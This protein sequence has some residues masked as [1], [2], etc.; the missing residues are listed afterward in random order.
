MMKKWLEANIPGS[1]E[2]KPMRDGR[3]LVLAKNQ[4]TASKAIQ[5]EITFTTHV[6]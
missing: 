6:I 5:K 1:L 2:A 3:I 4:E